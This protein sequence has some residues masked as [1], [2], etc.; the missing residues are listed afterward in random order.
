MPTLSSSSISA[1]SR[2]T[3]PFTDPPARRSPPSSGFLSA[4]DFYD[5]G[6]EERAV[7]QAELDARKRLANEAGAYDYVPGTQD[8]EARW[9]PRQTANDLFARSRAGAGDLQLGDARVAHDAANLPTRLGM[10][11]DTAVNDAQAKADAYWLPGTQSMLENEVDRQDRL[12]RSRWLDP[13]LARN[14][15]SATVADINRDARLGAAQTTAEGRSS[16]VLNK[17]LMDQLTALLRRG[18]V[19]PNDPDSMLKAL[20]GFMSLRN[21]A[22]GAGGG[23]PG[24]ASNGGT[25][26]PDLSGLAPGHGRTFSSGPFAG[27][28]W[29]VDAQGQPQRVK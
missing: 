22:V 19:N 27:Q 7:Y 20:Q 2:L 12:N 29:A 23:V 6:P 3:D 24:A 1:L 8:I 17:G 21:G 13:V 28:T 26:V 14:A 9:L 18:D 4:E 16:D 15:G 5:L 11:H 25:G 10:A